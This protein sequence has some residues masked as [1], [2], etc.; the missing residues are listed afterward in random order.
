MKPTAPAPAALT[1][2]G[3]GGAAAA[4][5]PA[6]GEQAPPP[7][8]AA[9]TD[10]G[11]GG[12]AGRERGDT[13]HR[14]KRFSWRARRRATERRPCPRTTDASGNRGG[15]SEPAATGAQ[16]FAPRPRRHL[17]KAGASGR[18]GAKARRARNGTAARREAAERERSDRAA[19]PSAKP[20][21]TAR[22]AHTFPWRGRRQPPQPQRAPQRGHGG[23]HAPHRR[24]S[25]TEKAPVGA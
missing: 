24:E 21:G 6:R 25:G 13:S 3:G 12:A 5:P 23:S 14:Y 18:P 1:G 10:A 22:R 11:A 9:Q 7:Q 20:T 15:R 16:P 19:K 17:P 4:Q 2:G 8:L